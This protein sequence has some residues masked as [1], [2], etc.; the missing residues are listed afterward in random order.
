MPL[1]VLVFV[2]TVM[3]SAIIMRA[4]SI[5]DW[6]SFRS[7]FNFSELTAQM[8]KVKGKVVPV[9]NQLKHQAM[10]TYGGLEV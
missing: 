2:A 5:A 6:V 1:P 9:F 10:K 7:S 4:L 3:D 8:N